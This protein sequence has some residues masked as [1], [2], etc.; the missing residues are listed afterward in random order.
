MHFGLVT[1]NL[2]SYADPQT[3]MQIG[4]EKAGPPR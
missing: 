3:V 1:T 2:G 4:Q